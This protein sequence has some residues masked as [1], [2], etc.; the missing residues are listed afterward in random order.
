MIFAA[1]G[2]TGIVMPSCICALNP[3]NLAWYQIKNYVRS[4]NT[5]QDVML[6][7]REDLVEEGTRE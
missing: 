4:H 6:I 7:R 5:I 1:H 2:G 3:I